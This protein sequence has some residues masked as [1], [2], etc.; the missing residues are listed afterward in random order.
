MI[1]K[2]EKDSRKGLL[3]NI[4]GNGKGKTT[5]ALGNCMRALGWGWQVSMIQFIK[6]KQENGEKHFIE[7]IQDM[8]MIQCGLG[9]TH[10]S[11]ASEA[12]HIQAAQEAWSKAKFCLLSGEIDLLVLDELN[13]VLNLGWLEIDEVISVLQKRPGWMHVIITGRNA[14]DKIIVASD[15]VS[16]IKEIKHPYKSGIKAQKGI[17]Y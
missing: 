6:N 5:S 4:T 8:E 1:E 10:N 15:L 7:T 16:E 11:K 3:I 2:R 9:L 17:E 13:I 14:T 12:Q